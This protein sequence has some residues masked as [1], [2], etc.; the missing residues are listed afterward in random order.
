MMATRIHPDM[1]L[2]TIATELPATGRQRDV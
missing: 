1:T 2:N